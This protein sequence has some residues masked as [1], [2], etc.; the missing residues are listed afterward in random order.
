MSCSEWLAVDIEVQPAR[1]IRVQV[2]DVLAF[3]ASQNIADASVPSLIAY[4]GIS[5]AEP[6]ASD[7][8][9]H[10]DNVRLDVR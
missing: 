1:L 5:F 3:L 6:A 10:Y 7:W 8:V 2:N 9:V 4:V